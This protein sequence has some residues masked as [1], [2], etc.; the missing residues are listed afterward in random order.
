MA[1]HE[2]NIKYTSIIESQY[3]TPLSLKRFARRFKENF[4]T[5]STLQIVIK[6][7]LPVDSVNPDVGFPWSS[8]DMLLSKDANFMKHKAK[9]TD[10][11]SFILEIEEESSV[12]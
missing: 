9:K 5:Y 10:L 8:F 11:P 2:V 6:S 12:F 4:V 7:F 1:Y 3:L